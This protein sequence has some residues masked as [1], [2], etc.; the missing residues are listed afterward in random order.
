V[1]IDYDSTYSYADRRL[2]V[3]NESSLLLNCITKER[4]SDTGKGHAAKKALK[5]ET[6]EPQHS[7]VMEYP[8]VRQLY[9]EPISFIAWRH[10][11]GS[12]LFIAS[13]DIDISASHSRDLICYWRDAMILPC[14]LEFHHSSISRII[15]GGLGLA[16]TLPGYAQ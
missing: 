6:A 13:L 11:G 10:L 7:S 8:G 12:E 16:V 3:S 14:I 5:N 9:L 1:S 2:H 4:H 15:V